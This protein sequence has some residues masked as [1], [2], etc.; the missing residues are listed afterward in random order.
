MRPNPPKIITV[1]VAALL[2]LAGLALI[3]FQP[4]AERLVKQ[5]PLGGDSSQFLTWVRDRTVAYILLA[6]SPILLIFGSLL[7]GL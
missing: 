4:E 7:K 1:V 5:L 3:Y 6:A 2:L